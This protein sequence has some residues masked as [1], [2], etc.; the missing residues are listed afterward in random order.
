MPKISDELLQQYFEGAEVEPN[1]SAYYENGTPVTVMTGGRRH[2][3]YMETVLQYYPLKVHADGEFPTVM[4]IM[5]RP[6]ETDDIL[7]YRKMT[8]KPITK[9]P[10]SKVI[11]SLTK[12]RRSPDWT[13]NFNKDNIPGKIVAEETLENY[14]SNNLP[15]YGS[16][17]DWAFNILLKQNAIDANAVIAVLPMEQVQ[18]NAYVKPVP[19]IFNSDHVI[20]YNEQKQFAI[21]KSRRKIDYQLDNE[22]FQPGYRFY[23]ID[24]LEF[25]IYEQSKD[26]FV[27]VMQQSHNLGKMPVFKVRGESFKSYDNMVVNRSRLDAMIPFLD[28][29][30]CE[31]SDLK[32][33]KI[34]HLYPLFWYYQNKNCAVCNGVGK[35]ATDLGDKECT[36]CNGT[37]KIK[38]SPYAHI[39][40]DPPSIGQTAVPNPPAGYITRD[41]AILGLQEASVESN[42]FKSLSAIN[43]Q[44]LDQTPLNVSAV[45]KAVDREELT[46][47]VYNFAEDLI[48]SIDRTIFW[49][50]E[51][52]YSYIVPDMQQRQDMLPNIPV[53]MNFDLLPANYLMDEITTARRN[54]V[55]PFLLATLEQQLAAKKF[56]NEPELA[57]TI[58]LFFDL[59]PLSGYTIDE[60]TTLR[61]NSA[62]TEEDFVISSYMAQFIRRALLDN[63]KFMTL[64][65]DAQ[66]AVLKKYADEKIGAND[67]AAK[68]I[69]DARQSVLNEMN[70]ANGKPGGTNTGANPAPPNNAVGVKPFI[71]TTALRPE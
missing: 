27:P 59:D 54:S 21:L 61:G 35:I 6:S 53:P 26:G 71:S 50:N 29:A 42:I 24:D 37:G 5:R 45:A 13:I 3:T 2:S 69:N 15:G 65:Y 39:Q 33:S 12:I 1:I 8:Y 48:A 41:T 67:A 55:N 68:M 43:M 11:S 64:N 22:S 34:Q 10:I 60:K 30:A 62:I 25:I 46:N 28:E 19:L 31:Y 66:M 4:I 16:I 9:L 14:I 17:T 7:L 20:E 58:K 63:P 40:V 51:W 36:K 57:E 49:I 18:A 47:F 23:Y 38:F 52:R 70:A 44:F 32:G 56:Y